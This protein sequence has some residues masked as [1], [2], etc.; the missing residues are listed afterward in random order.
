MKLFMRWW[1]RLLAVS[2]ST[3]WAVPGEGESLLCTLS[4]HVAETAGMD[5]E[6]VRRLPADAWRQLPPGDAGNLGFV[7]EDVWVRL[8]C[9]V[10]PV[11]MDN[12]WSSWASRV[13]TS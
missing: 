4:Y 2:A 7:A 6:S 9:G 12:M 10:G 5:V 8:L 13:R 3:A 11:G 1:I